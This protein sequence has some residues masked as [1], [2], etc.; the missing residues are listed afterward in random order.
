ML[1]AIWTNRFSVGNGKIDSAHR[2]IINMIFRIA[3]LIGEREEAAL[4]ENF[5]LLELNICAYFELE[6]RLAEA[7]RH[8][9]TQHR[10][11]HQSLLNELQGVRKNLEEK[12]GKWSDGD[13][14][15]FSNFWAKSFFQHIKDSEKLMQAFPDGY[16]LHPA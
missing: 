5:K 15:A 7:I 10:L 1:S 6:E 16:D 4:A 8:D 2:E 11:A 12:N 13:G 14:K 3:Y 9:F